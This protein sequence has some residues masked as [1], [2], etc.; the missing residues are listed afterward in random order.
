[1]TFRFGRDGASTWRCDH[2]DCHHQTVPSACQ[3]P[4]PSPPLP[5]SLDHSPFASSAETSAR[6]HLSTHPRSCL[7]LDALLSS[8]ASWTHI[9]A[10]RRTDL[11]NLHS[12]ISICKRRFRGQDPSTAVPAERT[13]D[14]LVL[15]WLPASNTLSSTHPGLPSPGAAWSRSFASVFGLFSRPFGFAVAMAPCWPMQTRRLSMP[16]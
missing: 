9:P 8:C 12:I 5:P 7:V 11:G 2:W 4:S 3:A 15:C 14:S 16:T 6:D 13:N 1:M 10:S